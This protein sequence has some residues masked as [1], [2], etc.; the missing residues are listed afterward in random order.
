LLSPSSEAVLCSSN[1][2][3]ISP[4][5][6]TEERVRPLEENKTM[7]LMKPIFCFLLAGIS[8]TPAVEES[9]PG[10]TLRPIGWVRKDHQKT[11]IVIDREFQPGLLGLDGFSHVYVL[12][13]FDR[14]DNPEKRSVLQV[15]PRGNPSN[16]LSGVFATRSP[17]RPNLIALSLCRI[18]EI[19]DNIVEIDAIDA[20]PDSPVLDLKPF[21]PHSEAKDA[22]VPDWIGGSTPEH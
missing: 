20:L 3:W 12:Y 4:Q 5:A 18:I 8:C 16:P 11:R 14:N 19:K 15:H 6:A 22:I 10:F 9:T 17:A 7:Y 1:W 2:L 13:W 21:T